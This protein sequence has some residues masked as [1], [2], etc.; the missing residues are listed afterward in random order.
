MA[1]F[2]NQI[3]QY[4]SMEQNS[5]KYLHL[6]TGQ[7]NGIEGKAGSVTEKDGKKIWHVSSQ[8]RI[9]YHKDWQRFVSTTVKSPVA[10]KTGKE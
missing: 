6:Q 3:K 4:Q 5:L 7:K 2:E 9:K 10:E 1:I 8:E